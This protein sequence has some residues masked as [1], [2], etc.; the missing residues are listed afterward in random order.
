MISFIFNDKDSYDD[1]GIV[2]K[3]RPSIPLPERNVTHIE[4]PGRNGTLTEDDGTYKD[5]EITLDCFVYDTD[6]IY[7]KIDKMKGWIT[8]GKADLIFSYNPNVKYIGQVV[9][10]TDIIQNFPTLGEFSIKIT[11]QPFSYP[12]FNPTIEIEEQNT[13]ITNHFSQASSPKITIHG[14]GD[15]TLNITDY[16]NDIQIVEL[17]NVVDYITI[18]SL[19]MECYKDNTLTNNQMVGYFPKINI[20]DNTISWTGNVEKIE[21]ISNFASV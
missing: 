21:V 7:E 17:R 1:F 8:Q 20:G 12:V 16:W 11:C 3:S 13:I 19:L 9:S 10:G 18:D 14:Q 4:I 2:L 5:I 6:Y 15:I